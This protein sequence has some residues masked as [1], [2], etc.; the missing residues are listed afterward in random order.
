MGDA[1]DWILNQIAA[2]A[3]C[4]RSRF[5]SGGNHKNRAR[6]GWM[7]V[8]APSIS[9]CLLLLLTRRVPST[10]VRGPQVTV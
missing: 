1:R 10:R 2:P 5:S 3:M 4:Q 6:G 7:D 9:K 8:G